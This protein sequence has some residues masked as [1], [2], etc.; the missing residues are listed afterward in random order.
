M[1]IFS[2]LADIINSN[3]TALL[4]KAE[5]PQKM[6]RLIIQEMEDELVK[7]RSNL[8]RFLASQK[9]IGRQVARHQ[10]RVDEWQ[11]KAELALTKGREDLAR[12]AL[13]EK[14]K[15]TELSET[16]YRE[17]QAVDSGIEKLGEEIRQLEAKLEDARARQKAMAIRTEAASS[18]LNVQSQVA[19]GESQAVVSKFERI[20]RR[21]DEMEAR[22]DLGQSDKALAQQF[23]ELEVDDQISRELEAMRQ[24][25]GQGD[26]KSEGKQGE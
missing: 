10:E 24:K 7:E 15:Q 1:S 21:I 9:E 20:E 2:R 26:S 3:L 16:L 25:L 5:D 23:A 13:I 22:A 14:K 17:Q 8:A 6:V 12:A 19:R 11:A 18:R 4:D